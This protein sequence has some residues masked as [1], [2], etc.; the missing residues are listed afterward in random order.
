MAEVL[1]W[2]QRSEARATLERAV[3]ALNEG[4]LV[5]FPTETTYVLAARADLP[6]VGPLLLHGTGSP[7]PALTF[8]VG[9]VAQALELAPGLS[10]MGRRLAR[11]CWPGPVTLACAGGR[12]AVAGL[13]D[14]VRDR[15]AAEG[16]GLRSPAHSA[17]LHALHALGAPLV[18][19]PAAEA[20]T[21]DDM[22]R[23]A[24]AEVAVV[25]D[26][27]ECRL[28][29]SPTVVRLVG[30]GWEV[31]HEG[32][33]PREQIQAR[34]AA[35]VL[36]VCTGNTCRSPLAEAL[37]KKKLA[38]RL[39]C[40]EEELPQRGF[41]VLSAGVA[42]Q[43]GEAAAEPAVAVAREYGADLTRHASQP[44]DMALAA[45][46]DHLV[47]MTGGHREVLVGALPHL[48]CQPRLLSPAGTDLPDPIGQ[49]ESVYR[50]CAGQIWQ[51]LEV[52]V[53]ELT[54]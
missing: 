21:A 14:A 5:A 42:A 40:A 32:V 28:G 16:F 54:A 26:D 24:G 10:A 9:G 51:D 35:L 31:V 50:A 23:T 3:Q 39:G 43:E 17:I 15:A 8:G 6:A 30:D 38:D 7:E 20:R 4:L 12:E 33:V 19:R 2:Q 34:T 37:C 1:S 22:V 49:D 36:F 41:L 18:L 46:A 25:V 53:A 48:G 13:P 29:G 44:L 45:Q 52:L 47:C 27:G 11:R